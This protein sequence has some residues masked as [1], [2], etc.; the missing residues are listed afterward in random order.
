MEGVIIVDGP[1]RTNV[2]EIDL[3]P[4]IRSRRQG[5]GESREKIS[6]IWWTTSVSI[7]DGADPDNE[8]LR[9]EWCKSRARLA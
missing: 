6:W 2:E 5:T 9:R 4:E 8:L 1:T 3:L 7:E